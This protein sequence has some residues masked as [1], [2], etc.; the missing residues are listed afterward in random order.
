MKIN[1]L[2]CG[3]ILASDEGVGIHAV[4]KMGEKKLPGGVKLMEVGRPGSFLLDYIMDTDIIIVIDAVAKGLKPGTV[5]RFDSN[6]YPPEE[7]LGFTIHGFNLVEAY[8]KG[9]KQYPDR[10]PKK[11]I[12]YGVEIKERGKFKTALSTPIKK[13]I[14]K[15][16]RE[17]K[18]EAL[19][20][21][22]T[23]KTR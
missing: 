21:Y 2:G 3:N 20:L 1:V 23:D 6:E 8:K 19:N 11:I 12:V 7:L 5:F 9:I 10:M 15:L 4:R 14:S 16:V 18:K 17:I 13:A 22:Q